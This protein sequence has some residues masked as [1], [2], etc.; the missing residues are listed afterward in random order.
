MLVGLA[1]SYAL[2]LYGYAILKEEPPFATW[3]SEE[4]LLKIPQLTP[5][6]LKE[7]QHWA[8]CRSV[9]AQV[10]PPSALRLALALVCQS[11]E[12][13]DLELVASAYKGVDGFTRK[14]VWLPNELQH[15]W[16]LVVS[17]PGA[18]PKRF[19]GDAV[20]EMVAAVAAA[21]N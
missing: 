13:S 8:V 10:A 18:E 12:M 20:L 5:Q 4:E 7:D 1:P 6:G 3:L 16:R 19:F 14:Q 17:A 9:L 21:G 15:L 2:P 11:R